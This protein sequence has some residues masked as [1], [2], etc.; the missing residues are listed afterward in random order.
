MIKLIFCVRRLSHLSR[1]AFQQYWRETH[2][3]LVRRHAAVLV[4]Q[5]HAGFCHACQQPAAQ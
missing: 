4:I 3:P 5:L 2:G 1:D